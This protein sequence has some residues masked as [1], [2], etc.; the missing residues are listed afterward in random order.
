VLKLVVWVFKITKNLQKPKEFVFSAQHVKIIE[1]NFR[2]FCY[3]RECNPA[4]SPNDWDWTNHF[5]NYILNLVYLVLIDY[6]YLLSTYW[7]T[8][9]L[10]SFWYLEYWACIL[11]ITLKNFLIFL[12]NGNITIVILQWIIILYTQTNLNIISMSYEFWDNGLQ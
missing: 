10:F 4:P 3:S 1:Q 5:E 9:C 11:T 8:P 6:Y 7:V 12:L 2:F